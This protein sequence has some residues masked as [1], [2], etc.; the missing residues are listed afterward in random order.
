MFDV[1]GRAIAAGGV[2]IALA[3]AKSRPSVFALDGEDG[4]PGLRRAADVAMVQTTD[5]G[6]GVRPCAGGSTARGSGAS[7][8]RAR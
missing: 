3:S 5:E 8:S 4:R 1:A 6:Q 7:F 2:E